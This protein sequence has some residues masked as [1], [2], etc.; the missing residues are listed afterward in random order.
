LD[1]S[2]WQINS[3]KCWSVQYR[4]CD[5]VDKKL[6]HTYSAFLPALNFLTQQQLIDY[7]KDSLVLIQH[8]LVAQETHLAMSDR[9]LSIACDGGRYP[10]SCHPK[11]SGD[12]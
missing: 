11:S 3:Y 12:V 4:S 9:V 1:C 2:I 6:T 8:N 5:C 10:Q 7:D